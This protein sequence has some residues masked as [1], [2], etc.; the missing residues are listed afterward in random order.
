MIALA[1]AIWLEAS[2]LENQSRAP[3]ETWSQSRPNWLKDGEM[4][5]RYTRRTY[6]PTLATMQSEFRRAAQ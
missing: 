1:E 5:D 2:Y 3:W 6:N 4:Y